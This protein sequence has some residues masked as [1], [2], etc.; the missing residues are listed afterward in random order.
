MDELKKAEKG[1]AKKKTTSKVAKAEAKEIVETTPAEPA[2][3]FSLSA[4]GKTLNKY[5]GK[6]TVVVVP[7]GVTEISSFA[8]S[9]T[10]VTSVTLPDS[11]KKIGQY[12]FNGC[13]KLEQITI[14]ES[15]KYIGPM[16][17][18]NCSNL[19]KVILPEGLEKVYEKAFFKCT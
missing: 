13:T 12:A 6:E 9:D 18:Y 7:D 19:K 11:V 16:A 8:F 3:P 15:V 4:S 10:K 17:F 14:P 1:P 2:A 5:E